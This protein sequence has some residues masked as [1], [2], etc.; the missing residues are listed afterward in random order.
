MRFSLTATSLLA[1]LA[2]VGCG[3]DDARTP[4]GPPVA[5]DDFCTE[6]V[7]AFCDNIARCDCSPTADADCRADLA[8]TCGGANGILGPEA[9]ARIDSGKVRYDAASAGAVFAR[10]RATSSCDNSLLSLGWTFSDVL[11]FGGVFRGTTAAGAACSTTN[12]PV[13]GECAN[14][15]CQET[16][17]GGIC[18]GL[19]AAGAPCGMGMP[20]LCANTTLPFTSLE[21]SDLLLRCDIPMGATSGVCA[22]R[23]ANGGTCGSELD[24]AS[25][26]CDGMVCAPQRA[27]GAMCADDSE[28]VSGFCE[29]TP[30]GGTCRTRSL[31]PV[32]ASCTDPNDCESDECRDGVCVAG[33]CGLYDPPPPPPN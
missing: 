11:T 21:D 26:I 29:M 19:A 17:S 12:S 10:V 30:D 4:S 24:C 3:D 18:I 2:L 7:D 15:I 20:Y 16:M 6:F 33:I 14:G 1:A 27:A 5:I 31:A 28:C 25:T 9:R 22:A 8:N 13:A 32:G 23:L